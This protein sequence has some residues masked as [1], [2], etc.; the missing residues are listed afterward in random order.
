MKKGKK[1]KVGCG[2]DYF[3]G[4]FYQY[5]FEWNGHQTIIQVICEFSALKIYPNKIVKL[6]NC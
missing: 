2:M 1:D 4:P 3:G 6:L 5:P